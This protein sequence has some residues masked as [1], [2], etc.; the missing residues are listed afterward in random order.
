MN[1]AKKLKTGGHLQ[2]W[3]PSGLV[4]CV[5][6]PMF[7][8]TWV[9]TTKAFFFF[10]FPGRAEHSPTFI[11]ELYWTPAHFKT[12]MLLPGVSVTLDSP[13]NANK[14]Q[15]GEALIHRNNHAWFFYLRKNSLKQTAFLNSTVFPVKQAKKLKIGGHL[16]FWW[17]SGLVPSVWNPLYFAVMSSNPQEGFFFFFFFFFSGRCYTLLTPGRLKPA[18]F[19]AWGVG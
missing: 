13:R 8:Q 18:T 10:F 19:C 14:S 6:N 7:L 9:R 4:P 17:P 16:Q 3:W 15:A 1:Q 2:F 5:W 12:R 11:Q